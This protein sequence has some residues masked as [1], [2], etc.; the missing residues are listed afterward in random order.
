[1]ES[2]SS[3]LRERLS[4]L[5]ENSAKETLLLLLV[6]VLLLIMERVLENFHFLRCN[7]V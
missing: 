3:S 7:T 1:M 5:L 2:V 6:S 4:L